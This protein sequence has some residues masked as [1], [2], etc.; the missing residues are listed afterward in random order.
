MGSG[1][2]AERPLPRDW[3]FMA[4]VFKIHLFGAGSLRFQE[5]T[6]LKKPHGNDMVFGRSPKSQYP[7]IRNSLGGKLVYIGTTLHHNPTLRPCYRQRPYPTQ[8]R[9]VLRSRDSCP[10]SVHAQKELKTIKTLMRIRSD[11]NCIAGL[12]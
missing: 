6:R 9:W 3:R 4:S 12:A 7:C 5:L 8:K 1:P 11:A 2:L 10:K